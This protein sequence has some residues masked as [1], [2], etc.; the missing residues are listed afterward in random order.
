MYKAYNSDD[1]WH[2]TYDG[3]RWGSH[4]KLRA[5]QSARGPALAAFGGRLHLVHR[6]GGSDL[7]LYH[8]TFDGSSWSD[9][10]QLRA[11]QTASNPALAEYDGK[12]HLL[13]RGGGDTYLYHAIFNGSSWSD[14]VK[15]PRHQSLEGPTLAVLGGQLYCIHRGQGKDD[16]NLYW[17]KYPTNGGWSPDQKFPGHMSD[18]GPGAVVYKDKNGTHDQ[19]MVVHR[20]RGNRAA[21]TDTA[22]VEA[23]LA[24][25]QAAAGT[26]DA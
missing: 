2:A 24:A 18:A 3:T 9:D 1:L 22:E 25:E 13:H 10:I 14:D 21:G 7:N 26:P 5:H 23:R 4:S 15:L 8:A 16:Q 6:G 12:L 17:T 11:H 19:I 20:G